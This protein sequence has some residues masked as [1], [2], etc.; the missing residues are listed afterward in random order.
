[1][2]RG[3]KTGKQGRE[4][5]AYNESDYLTF[6]CYEFVCKVDFPNWEGGRALWVVSSRKGNW[7][8][9]HAICDHSSPDGVITIAL[10]ELLFLSRCGLKTEE[11]SAA[12]NSSNNRM[13]VKIKWDLPRR[14][15]LQLGKWVQRVEQVASSLPPLAPQSQPLRAAVLPCLSGAQLPSPLCQTPCPPPPPACRGPI[16]WP[17]L[18][19]QVIVKDMLAQLPTLGAW[20]VDLIWPLCITSF[21]DRGPH[22]VPWVPMQLP[23]ISIS[24]QLLF[25][26]RDMELQ[27]WVLTQPLIA[28]IIRT[29]LPLGSLTSMLTAWI[30]KIRHPHGNFRFCEDL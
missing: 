8:F 26:P 10:K 19:L 14:R 1:M 2:C 4:V 27:A 5:L 3:D 15:P 13:E 17:I 24:P 23:A 18:R 12:N 22:S 28:W 25:P 20:T 11:L 6:S 9:G 16:L 30:I 7:S 21:L 29:K